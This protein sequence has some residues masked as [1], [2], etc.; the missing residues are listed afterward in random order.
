MTPA[1]LLAEWQTRQ[2]ERDLRNFARQGWH[3]LEPSTPYVPSWHLD[4][5]DDHLMACTMGHIT[6]LVINIPPRHSKSLRLNVFWPAWTWIRWPEWRFLF[7]SYKL[8]LAIRDSVKT[9]RLISSPF[10]QRRWGARYRITTDQ[11]TKS[12]F[13]NDKAGFRITGSMDA[14]P[15]G[16]GGHVVA[17]DDPTDIK[18]AQNASALERAVDVFDQVLSTRLN[19]QKTGIKI[20]TMQRLSEQDLSA[21]C[22]AE[23]G[24]VH[25]NLPCEYDPSRRCVTVGGVRPVPP[26]EPAP[27]DDPPAP[28]TLY[29]QVP[30][31]D[32]RSEEGELLWPARIGPEEVSKLKGPTGLGVWGFENQ[33]NQNPAPRA[34]GLFKRDNWRYWTLLPC[35]ERGRLRFDEMA[36]S[37]DCTFKDLD[38][39]DWVVIQVWGRR[40]PDFYLLHQIRERLGFSA[41][42]E[43]V[44]LVS[45]H[46]HWRRAH[47]KLIEDKANG[48]AVIEVLSRRVPGVLAITPE[49]GKL[50]RAQATVPFHEAHNIHIPHATD[51]RLPRWIPSDPASNQDDPEAAGEFVLE[52]YPC[53]WVPDFVQECAVFPRAAHDDQVDS[54]TQAV[55][56]FASKPTPRIRAIR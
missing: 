13:E 56:W 19:D 12:A 25:L 8:T 23:A 38:T 18:D 21:H 34:G 17:V 22:L 37:V 3:V 33:Y 5:I 50:A 6:R 53:P 29:E 44:E 42:C 51:A 45:L 36:L 16:E 48:P 28:E 54:M 43:A 39:S 35:N 40:G 41:T 11:N 47:A 1:D 7:I 9:R 14:P 20:V 46:P 32:P 27:G 49:G 52:D 24:Y 2:A 15:T 55:I 4:A 30:F 10:Y 26:P 31:E